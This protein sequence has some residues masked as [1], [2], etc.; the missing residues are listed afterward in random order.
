[1][2]TIRVVLILTAFVVGF[3]AAAHRSS[4][5]PLNALYLTSPGLYHDYER[6]AETLTDAIAALANVRFDISLQD[7]RRWAKT[8]FA[9]GYDVV[10]YNV[11]MA[12]D[13]DAD[14]IANLR[15]QTEKRGVPAVVIHCTMHSFRTTELWW[16]FVGLKTKTH[17]HL[18]PMEITRQDP[19]PITASLPDGWTVESDEL[20][21]NLEFRGEALLTSPGEDGEPHVVAWTNDAEGTPVFGT[22][23]GHS[24]STID[25][26]AF[27]QLLASALL[28][29]TGNLSDDG[30]PSPGYEPVSNAP[31]RRSFSA[32]PGMHYLGECGQSEFRSAIGPCYLGCVA[33]PLLWGEDAESCKSDCLDRKPSLKELLE[34]CP[35]G[36]G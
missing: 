26:P 12:D 21:V 9:D 2:P 7:S 18:H 34:A 29:V 3:G 17:E 28:H 36:A 25:D 32:G 11:C 10:V 4:A 24:N 30:R 23:L 16:P 19:H 33:N 22:T 15:R 8:D 14:L 5:A 27:Q 31:A 35:E 1:M 13:T 6:Q 20:Y